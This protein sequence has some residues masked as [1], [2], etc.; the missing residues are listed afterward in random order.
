MRLTIRRP[1]DCPFDKYATVLNKYNFR[2]KDDVAD[3]WVIG[4]IEVN[5]LEELKQLSEELQHE[6]VMF[7]EYQDI[8][9]YDDYIE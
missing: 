9:I 5:S 7:G 6:L 3:G 1:Y 2:L 4:S 8:L